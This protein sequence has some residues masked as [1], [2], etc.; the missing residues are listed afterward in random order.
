[1]FSPREIPGNRIAKRRTGAAG[2]R[3]HANTGPRFGIS[4]KINGLTE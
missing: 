2:F 3:W 1:M 4:M